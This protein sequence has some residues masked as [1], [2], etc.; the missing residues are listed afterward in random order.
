MCRLDSGRLADDKKL[1]SAK[2]TA[3]L[4]HPVTSKPITR[5]SEEL[6]P[7]Q[8][9]FYSYALGFNVQDY[10]SVKLVTHTGGLPGYVSRLAMIPEI[11]LGVTVLTNQESGAAFNAVVYHVLDHYLGATGF[12]WIKA[13]KTY[14]DNR[15]AQYLMVEESAQQL[16]VTDTKPSL[17]KSAYA[18]LYRDVWYGDIKIELKND[19]LE[20]QFVH[21][22]DLHG[23]LIHW[24]HD[25]FLAKWYD[26][27]LRGDAFITFSLDPDG[28]IEQAKMKPFSP[29]VDFS[30]DY[31]D[32]RL[33]PVDEEE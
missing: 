3:E 12:D 16:R 21:T 2:T 26:R 33:M 24:Q 8:M 5:Y 14:Y 20:I 32:L 18:G 29:A 1:F 17:E 15:A 7:L 4:W 6:A 25:T 23:E 22:P 10:R 27:S 31:Q 19:K 13:Y 11:K 28:K 30:F 9:N